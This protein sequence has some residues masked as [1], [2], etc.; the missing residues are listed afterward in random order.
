MGSPV[1]QGGFNAWRVTNPDSSEVI[2]QTLYDFALYPQAGTNQ[3]S[4]FSNPAGQGVTTAVGAVVG[5]P[6]SQFDTNIPSS[7]QLPSGMEF[8]IETIEVAFEPG[9]SAVANTYSP[10]AIA[11]LNAVANSALFQPNNDVNTFYESGMLVFQVLAKTYLQETPLKK[12]PPKVGID[13]SGA[14]STTNA[15]AT[16]VLQVAKA[17]GRPYILDPQIALQSAVNFSV[18]L[19]YPAA[20]AMPS[21][22]NGRVGVALDGYM[23]RASQ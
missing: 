20:V 9:T 13:I 22:F 10:A 3:I 15:A 11:A 17:V 7:N 5:Q 18:Q 1:V 2:R 4:F 14:V 23:K 6:K 19:Q 16:A 8:L 21:G 12:F